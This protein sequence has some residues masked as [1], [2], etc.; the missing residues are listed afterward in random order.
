MLPARLWRFSP[1]QLAIPPDDFRVL[2]AT[3]A[4]LGPAWRAE[5]VPLMIVKKILTP[6]VWHRYGSGMAAS[7]DP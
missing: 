4:G 1:L 6:S 3:S 5:G 2:H 7:L